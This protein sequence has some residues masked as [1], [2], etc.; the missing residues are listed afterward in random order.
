[1]A[2]RLAQLTQK[3]QEAGEKTKRK[4]KGQRRRTPGGR[5]TLAGSTPQGV[6][7][8]A[9]ATSLTKLKQG[10]E[11]MCCGSNGPQD[12]LGTRLDEGC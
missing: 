3:E 12:K 4:Q 7:E 8:T 11:A 5:G 1:M 6:V 9:A 2:V 10:E